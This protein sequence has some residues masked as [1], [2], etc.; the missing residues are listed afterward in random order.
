MKRLMLAGLVTLGAWGVVSLPPAQAAP[1]T[2]C[3]LVL[4]LPCPE[5][6]RAIGHP[7]NCCK[8]VPAPQAGPLSE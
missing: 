4:C 7:P 6:T 1:P 8:C 3:S 2:P 5:G